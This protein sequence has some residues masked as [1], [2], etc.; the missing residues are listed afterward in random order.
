MS[1]DRFRRVFGASGQK[2]TGGSQ[3]W[4]DEQLISANKGLERQTQHLGTISSL[5]P[6]AHAEHPDRRSPGEYDPARRCPFGVPRDG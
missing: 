4:R 1:L 5:Y 2:T 6:T 3:Q